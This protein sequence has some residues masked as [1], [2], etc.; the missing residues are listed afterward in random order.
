M[1]HLELCVPLRY[2]RSPAEE[3][4]APLRPALPHLKKLDYT[5]VAMTRA[6]PPKGA[7]SN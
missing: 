7:G 6:L 2:S 5:R 4:V 1:E 3:V